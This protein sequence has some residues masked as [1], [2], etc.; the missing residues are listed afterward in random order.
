MGCMGGCYSTKQS[1][2]E[3]AQPNERMPFASFVRVEATH[4]IQACQTITDKDG[5]KGEKCTVGAV[6]YTSSGAIIGHSDVDPTIAY[7]L[8][9]GHSC[10]KKIKDKKIDGFSLTTVAST[11]VTLSYRG[12]LKGAEIVAY[13]MTADVCVLKVTGYKARHRPRVIPISKKMPR[14]GEKVY[15]PAAPRGIFG[16]GMLLMFDGYYAGVG[17]KSYMFF[18]LPTKPGSSGSPILN[19]KGE[20]VS[21]IFAG[22][23]AMESV[24]LGSNL[25][26]IR[27]FV[28]DTVV[29]SEMDLWARKNMSLDST[30]IKTI[31]PPRP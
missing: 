23:P 6:R 24:G 7:A 20:L 22:F 14:M 19:A 17:Y 13:D 18:T 25:N 21:M 26:S 1:L 27:T 15:N 29:S 3:T 8:T 31:E 2:T 5:K 4:A 9:A 30:E 16:P 12:V 11:Y 28:I 10:Q